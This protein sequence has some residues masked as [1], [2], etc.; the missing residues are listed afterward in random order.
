MSN[1]K[2]IIEKQRKFFYNGE[3][4]KL[5]FRMEKLKLLKKCILEREEEILKALKEDL[6]KHPFEAYETE[7]YMVIEELNYIMKNL[8]RWMKPK[9]VKTPFIHAIS[10]SY[11][12]SEPY[13]VSLIISPWNYPFQL[14]ILP[15]VGSIAGGNCAIIK[16]SAYSPNTSSV[17][18]RIVKDCFKEEFVA[19]IEG[20]REVNQSLLSEK[21][22]YIF[23]T[24]SVKVGKVV[25]ESASKNLTPI[26]LELGGKSPCIVYKDA[27]IDIAAKRIVWGKFLNAGQTCVAPDY[28]LV[29]KSIKEELLSNMKEYIKKFYGENPLN[30]N[31]FC[32]IINEKHFDRLLS[33]LNDGNIYIG[34]NH[35]KEQLF[36]EPTII[37]NISWE[38]KIMRDEIFG[39]ILP[40]IEYEEIKDIVEKINENP[41]PLALYLFTNSKYIEKEVMENISFG[42]GCINDTIIHLAT[43][44]MPFGGVGESGIGNYHGK[45]SFDT[46]THKKSILKKSNSIDLDFRYPPY[47][48]KLNLLKKIIK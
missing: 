26:T 38:D 7:I 13:G 25:M 33:N 4:K 45:S 3:T 21:F 14:S 28:L 29:H 31:D 10:S 34:G 6:N 44:Y 40:V 32:R 8:K 11:T 16:P 24:G 47:K 1:I 43:S 30:S 48:N 42:G 19:V 5:K 18:S 41:K 23:F 2:S 12:V 17:V 9:K 37:N 27:N 36:I 35:I 20:G 15:L 39:P 22:D 46:F